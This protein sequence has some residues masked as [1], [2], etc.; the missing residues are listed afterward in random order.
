MQ[1][2]IE[3]KNLTVKFSPDKLILD[4]LTL[5]IKRGELISLIGLN[6]SGKTTLVRAIAGLIKPSKGKV[7]RHTN[8][9]FY[10][11]QRS[12][13]DTSFPITVRELMDLFGKKPYAKYLKEV[14]M[15]D[16]LDAQ[17][18]KLSGGELQR[19][20]I[21]LALSNKP[22]LLLMDEPISGIDV[23]AEKSFY[24]MIERIRKEYDMAIVL[25]SHD[26]HVVIAHADKVWCLAKHICCQGTPAEVKSSKEFL[27]QFTPHLQPYKHRH[28]HVH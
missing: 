18:S 6:G 11:P 22:D 16:F 2:L 27:E 1:T 12:D 13:L 26:I 19:V 7:K 8:K 20:F 17:V 28:D 24:G 23:V 21:A 4:N 10:I 14:S 5:D 3:V 25:V 9:I 15:I